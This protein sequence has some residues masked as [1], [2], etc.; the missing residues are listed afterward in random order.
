[1]YAWQGNY[2]FGKESVHK[3]LA[4]HYECSYEESKQR[5]FKLL[6]GGIDKKT[7]ESLQKM[8]DGE[9]L[10][11]RDTDGYKIIKLNKKR[12]YG[13]SKFKYSFL[14]LSAINKESLKKIKINQI[15]C[16]MDAKT[17]KNNVELMKF[18][19][20]MLE[21]MSKIFRENLEILKE[22]EVTII[23][24]KDPEFMRLKLCKKEVDNKSVV[25]KIDIEKIIYTQKFNQ[26]ANTLI[27]N[28]RKNT[29]IK[30]FNK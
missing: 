21:E 9:V 3:H 16:N 10:S 18:E 13:N 30:F 22:G 14:K 29:N 17:L 5:T 8:K 7:R 27:S 28:L 2:D 25:S 4:K 12:F 19:N 1:M 11:F 26:M 20:L 23:L 15:S 24:K 6:Y